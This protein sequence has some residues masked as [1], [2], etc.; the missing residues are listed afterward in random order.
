MLDFMK[1][2]QE[3]ERLGV[4]PPSTSGGPAS[5][6]PIIRVIED[7]LYKTDPLDIK[8]IIHIV[9]CHRIALKQWLMALDKDLD[10]DDPPEWYTEIEVEAAKL[11]KQSLDN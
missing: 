7:A 11:R 9:M 6:I 8:R 1:K 3:I 2:E 10:G 4:I 5:L